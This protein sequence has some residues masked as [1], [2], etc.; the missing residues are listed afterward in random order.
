TQ[1]DP[2]L[3]RWNIGAGKSVAFT[4]DVTGKW[5]TDWVSWSSFPQVFTE[6]V[7]WTYPQFVQ[8]PYSVEQNGEG[9]LSIISHE[10]DSQSNLGMTINQGTQSQI[11]PL[12]PVASG[13]YEGD[14]S[15][16][17]SGVYFTQIGE[18]QLDSS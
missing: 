8:T 13:Q 4:S 15:G 9:K 7:R 2:I 1:E 5:S 10:A 14:V 17:E 16:L 18:R 12:V 3:A 6:W 11:V